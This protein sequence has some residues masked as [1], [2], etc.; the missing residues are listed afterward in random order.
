MKPLWEILGAFLASAGLLWLC[1]LC[2]GR[3]IFPAGRRRGGFVVLPVRGDGA[4]MEYDLAGLRWLRNGGLA[5]MPVILADDGL[6]DA[7]RVVANLLAE[8]DPYVLICPM[9]HLSACVRAWDQSR[10]EED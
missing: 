4:R 7:G 2:F 6:S 10:T 1:W 9:D 3:L 8:R 5:H